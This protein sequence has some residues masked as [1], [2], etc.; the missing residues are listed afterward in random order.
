MDGKG[1][2]EIAQED[3]LSGVDGDDDAVCICDCGQ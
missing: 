2:E 3:G 1:M